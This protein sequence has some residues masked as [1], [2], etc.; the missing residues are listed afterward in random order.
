MSMDCYYT[1][2]VYILSLPSIPRPRLILD[3]VLDISRRH[4][5]EIAQKNLGRVLD[6]GMFLVLVPPGAMEVVVKYTRSQEV[7]GEENI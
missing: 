2:N 6:I 4:F 1:F 7:G 5:Q 3:Y